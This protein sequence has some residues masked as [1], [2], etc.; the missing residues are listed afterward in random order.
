MMTRSRLAQSASLTAAALVLLVG[1]SA[2]GDS[3][4]KSSPSGSGSAPPVRTSAINPSALPTAPSNP[5][6]I[7]SSDADPAHNAH[8]L[9]T[10]DTTDMKLQVNSAKRDSSGIVTLTWTVVNNSDRDLDV[11]N[12]FWD[13]INGY[14]GHSVSNVQLTD[15]AKLVKYH[16]LIDSDTNCYC[17]RGGNADDNLPAG[18]SASYVDLFKPDPGTTKVDVDVAGFKPAKNVPIT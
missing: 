7:A 13:S 18:E 17:S 5:P 8:I 9:N 4:A 12:T 1:C 11:Y 3:H 14:Y 2:G 10:M 6:V 15:Q 16:P